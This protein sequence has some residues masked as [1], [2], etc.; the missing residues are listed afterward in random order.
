MPRLGAFGTKKATA[1]YPSNKCLSTTTTHDL[2]AT[3]TKYRAIAVYVTAYDRGRL[4]VCVG[5]GQM[6]SNDA[7]HR[8]TVPAAGRIQGVERALFLYVHVHDVRPQSVLCLMFRLNVRKHLQ[9]N[10]VVRTLT[11]A[12]SSSSKR[13]VGYLLPNTLPT[14]LLFLPQDSRQVQDRAH[15]RTNFM[16]PYLLIHFPEQAYSLRCL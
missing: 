2:P 15:P 12:C 13:Q 10:R 11:R 5:L 16:S 9:P 6:F 3:T 7:L 14:R 4:R 1:I 8:R